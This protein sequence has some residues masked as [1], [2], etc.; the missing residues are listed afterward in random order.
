MQRCSRGGLAA[1]TACSESMRPRRKY[2]EEWIDTAVEHAVLRLCSH[3]FFITQR[4]E[5]EV[6]C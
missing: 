2:N 6:A 5:V 3:L 4:S 1:A